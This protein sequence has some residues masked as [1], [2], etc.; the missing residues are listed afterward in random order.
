MD[1][2]VDLNANTDEDTF[3]REGKALEYPLLGDSITLIRKRL[4]GFTS[5]VVD[6]SP[7][8]GYSGST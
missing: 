3:G 4:L 8:A 6:D 7:S 5:R 1:D 2:K